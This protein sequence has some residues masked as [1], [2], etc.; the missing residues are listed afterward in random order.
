MV[1]VDTGA[2]Y[3]IMTLRAAETAGVTLGEGST[4][5]VG[6]AG[7]AAQPAVIDTLELGGLTLRNVP[8]LVGNAPALMSAN[9]QMAL[10]TELM[11]H[12]RFT[13]DYPA[14]RVYVERADRPA[15]RHDEAASVAW[16]LWTFS[17]ACLA[18]AET[19]RGPA[20]VMIDTGNRLGTYVSARWA[21]RHL[22]QFQRP[23]STLVFKFRH[24][25][26]TLDTMQ[27]GELV[28][29]D[30]PIWDRI[31]RE[32]EQLDL[33]DVLIG[34]DLLWPYR[35]TIDLHERVMRMEGGPASPTPPVESIP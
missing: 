26:L 5:L 27:V 23:T 6:F 22:P 7:L 3:T 8:V 32:L 10:G 21:R 29:R 16:P 25:G 13:L 31:P 2:Q 28:L 18:Q 33:V 24:Q 9:G 35:L 14:R 15:S 34:R 12:V 19:D 17:Q 4:E 1:F 30:W 20:R 11:H